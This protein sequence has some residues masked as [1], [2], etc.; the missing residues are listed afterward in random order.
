MKLGKVIQKLLWS[1]SILLCLDSEGW[2]DGIPNTLKV[3]GFVA[4]TTCVLV[5]CNLTNCLTPSHMIAYIYRIKILKTFP[6]WDL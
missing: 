2:R 5:F 4:Q 6:I 3:Q 1:H